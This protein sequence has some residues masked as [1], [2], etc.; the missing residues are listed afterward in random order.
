P[1]P[2]TST[3][4][5]AT[6]ASGQSRLLIKRRRGDELPVN[7]NP[8]QG[9]A[10]LQDATAA[11]PDAGSSTVSPSMGPTTVTTT[12][13]IRSGL[14]IKR[15][16]PLP[17]VG[18]STATPQESVAS[19]SAQEAKPHTVTL[20][21][22]RVTTVTDLESKPV[23]PPTGATASGT[24]AT[25]SPASTATDSTVAEPA[26]KVLPHGQKRR[27]ETTESVQ[28][29]ITIVSTPGPGDADEMEDITTPEPTHENMDVEE[30]PA[31]KRSRPNSHV[32]IAEIP[33]ETS[34]SG[35][36]EESA[37]PGTP[38]Q[39]GDYEDGAIEEEAADA[40]ETAVTATTTVPPAEAVDS[41]ETKGAEEEEHR[42]QEAAPET[43]TDHPL[44]EDLEEGLE[45]SYGTP[46]AADVTEFEEVDVHTPHAQEEEEGDLELEMDE[47]RAHEGDA[48]ASESAA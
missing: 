4:T 23:S 40:S 42:H 38:G 44:E 1:T 32:V 31:V 6:S 10:P 13:E 17:V 35:V 16:R 22:K 36:R 46:G 11:I 34:S 39:L 48:D 19:S 43:R 9:T 21:R 15:Q 25:T 47:H 2:P 26:S 41:T 14:M 33:G 24:E 12:S 18:G 5:A 8:P 30:T 7:L 28:E 20:Q 45:T 29:S 27:H 37:A 3:S